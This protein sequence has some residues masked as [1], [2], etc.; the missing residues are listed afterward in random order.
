MKPLFK[1]AQLQ[2]K[3]E[4]DGFIKIPLLTK[5]EVNELMAAYKTVADEH[6]RINIPYITTSHSNDAA[7]ITRVDAM[8]QSVMAP[9]ISRHLANYNL[10]F[11]NYLVK[12]PVAKSET[13]PHQDITFVDE[14]KHLSVNIWVALQD[15]NKENGCMYL[16]KGSHAFMD[17]LRPTH[18]YKW[19]YENVVDEIKQNS[20]S[21]PMKAGEAIIFNHAV[22]HG[23]FSNETNMPRV[24]AV[25][26]AYQNDAELLH[27]Y[28]PDKDKNVVQK[29]SMTKE[30]FLHFKKGCPPP[31]G[32]FLNEMSYEF[33]QVKANEF[34]ALLKKHPKERNS[35]VNSVL[36]L[37]K[38][39]E[40]SVT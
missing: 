37:F 25:I 18:D 11:G 23:S 34:N 4:K 9:A 26:A 30:A 29:F 28:L 12:M 24:A 13:S 40:R 19:C 14:S 36:N 2:S 38:Q 22:V 31:K 21:Y 35:I 1:S 27:F 3:F 16:L 7:L 15:T 17:T 20:E 5:A 10:L 32:V 6:E 39:S 33:K 8:L